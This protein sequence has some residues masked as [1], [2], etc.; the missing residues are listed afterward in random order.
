MS[1]KWTDQCEDCSLKK[2]KGHCY[3]RAFFLKRK[4]RRLKTVT[5]IVGHFSLN[6]KAPTKNKPGAAKVGAIS[7]AQNCK[8]AL[9]FVKLQLVAKYEKT[10]KGDPW[11]ILKNFRKTF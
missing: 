4:T 11:E 2:K 6:R 9:G 10:F 8:R 5:A 3:S 7:K 1:E